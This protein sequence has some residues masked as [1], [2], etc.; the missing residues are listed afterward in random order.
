MRA[1]LA[2]SQLA[3]LPQL[4]ELLRP[5]F[6]LVLGLAGI[7]TL[8][9]Y[10]ERPG[11]SRRT[12]VATVPWMIAAAALSIVG[13]GGAYPVRV[14]PAVSGPG[15]YL[16]V[17]AIGCLTWFGLL[18]FGR[19]SQGE[20][21]RVPALIA[22]MGLGLTFVVLTALFVDAGGITGGQ[23][24]W[25][26]VAPIASG[27]VAG[28]VLLLLGLWY[29]EAAAYTGAVGGLVVFGHAFS[30]IATAV[31]V[32]SGPGGHTS[33]SWAVLNVMAAAGLE[34]LLGFDQQLLWAWGYVWV[35]LIFA[36]LFVVA[37]T[38]YTR[39]HPSRGNLLLGAVGAVG[40]IGGVN[41]LLAM[42]V[43]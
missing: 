39:S 2:L 12:V 40:V 20:R 7:V 18:Q 16:T 1:P 3:G 9:L 29:P 4:A 42:V 34:N 21:D 27:A 28:V 43:A 17:Y 24:F 15:A 31:A 11:L 13:G 38:A 33:V 26:A 6:L 19:S 41:A 5:G 32:V 23:L 30:A 35:K 10:A 37:M 14:R 8:L 36:L 22:S 25:L